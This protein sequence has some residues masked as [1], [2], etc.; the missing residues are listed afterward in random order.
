MSVYLLR[1]PRLQCIQDPPTHCA[2]LASGTLALSS[3]CFCLVEV[4][5]LWAFFL[6]EFPF[7]DQLLSRGLAQTLGHGRHVPCLLELLA[8]AAASSTRSSKG[9]GILVSP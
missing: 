3:G 6:Q 9:S 1:M 2:S 7:M 8:N 5:F 4:Q